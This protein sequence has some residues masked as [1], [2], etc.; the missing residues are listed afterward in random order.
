MKILDK[1]YYC[2]EDVK[3]DQSALFYMITTFLVIVFLGVAIGLFAFPIILACELNSG[4]WALLW[5]VTVPLGVG[6]F[7]KLIEIVE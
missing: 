4:Y 6:V 7:C 2:W 1:I 5:L 3:R